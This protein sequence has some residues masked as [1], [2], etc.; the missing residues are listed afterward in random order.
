MI[1][2]KASRLA[3]VSL[4]SVAPPDPD[5]IFTGYTG[6]GGILETLAVLGVS[7]AAA[8]VGIRSAMKERRDPYLQ[9]AGW[10]AGIG[11]ALLGLL[12]L[13]TKTGLTAEVGLP[14]VR[15]APY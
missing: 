4:P 10:V 14:T 12:Y 2:L 6:A 1:D 8:W 13:G 9:A 5:A 3:Q 15:I 11:S 7:S